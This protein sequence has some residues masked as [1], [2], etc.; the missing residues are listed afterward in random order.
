LGSEEK[1]EERFQLLDDVK[2]LL[3]LS[4]NPRMLS[5]ISEIDGSEL[6]QARERAGE[7]TS[8]GLYRLLI[9][10]W[11]KNEFIRANPKGAPPGLSLDQLRKAATA[12]AMLLW[13]RTERTVKPSELP[14]GLLDDVQSLS[15]RPMEASN[16]AHQIGSGT[17]LVRDEDGNFGFIHQSVLEWLVA[18]E[19]ATEVLKTGD[20]AALGVRE[21]SDLMIDFFGDMA[22]PTVAMAWADQALLAVGGETAKKN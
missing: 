19:A 7:I 12:L 22:N 11:L 15:E 3:G 1:G 17:L 5:F 13:Q 2:D 20:S 4:A 14:Q 18:R 16:V 10:R 8:A 9:D 6:I 21:M